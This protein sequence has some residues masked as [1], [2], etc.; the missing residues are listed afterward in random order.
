MAEME[1]LN[2]LQE[3]LKSNKDFMFISFTWDNKKAIQRVKEKYGLSFTVLSVSRDEC[4]RLNFGGSYP[5]NIVLDKTGTIKYL[6]TG[7][8]T[9]KE[10]AREFVRSTLLSKINEL[11]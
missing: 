1:A 6:H 3:K 10:E 8:S 4:D 2:E 7:G 11:L 5:T 9:K